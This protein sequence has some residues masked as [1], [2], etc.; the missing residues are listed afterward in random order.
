MTDLHCDGGP[1]LESLERVEVTSET[2]LNDILNSEQSEIPDDLP[3]SIDEFIRDRFCTKLEDPGT[4][5]R[6][7]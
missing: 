4:G 1:I 2:N 7:R 6:I 3:K 5:R